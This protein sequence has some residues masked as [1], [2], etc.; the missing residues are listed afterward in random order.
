M[1]LS[2]S[3]PN[4][5]SGIGAH[6]HALRLSQR[7]FKAITLGVDAS[8]SALP[9]LF[10]AALDELLVRFLPVPEWIDDHTLVGGRCGDT[11]VDIVRQPRII[12]RHGGMLHGKTDV[13]PIVG[14]C[15]GGACLFRLR[16]FPQIPF[17][18][19]GLEEIRSQQGEENA[20]K[21][22][23]H[24]RYRYTSETDDWKE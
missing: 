12:R 15:G 21:E 14:L 24:G 22:L 6:L 2:F 11:R 8:L 18:V 13:D 9:I 17:A 7:H 23:S 10:D 19:G 5:F 1:Y 3:L 16:C 20:R 4:T